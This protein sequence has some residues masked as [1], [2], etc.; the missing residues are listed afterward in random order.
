MAQ[1]LLA[2]VCMTCGKLNN[3]WLWLCESCDTK[4][5]MDEDEQQQA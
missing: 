3:H 5:A 1:T 2:Y 4:A